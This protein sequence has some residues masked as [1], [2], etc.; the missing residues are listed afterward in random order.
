[1]AA[2]MKEVSARVELARSRFPSEADKLRQATRALYRGQCNCSYWH[3]AFGGLYLSHLRQAVYKNLIEADSIIASLEKP[4]GGAKS[5]VDLE[6]FDFNF[7]LQPEI[8]LSS[9]RIAAYVSPA[10]GGQ[11]Y[12][13]DVRETGT[14]LMATLAR[15]PEPY[16]AQLANSNDENLIVKEEGLASR[17][18]YDTR[19]RR[20]FVDKFLLE[21]AS[22]EDFLASIAEVGDFS[23]T[24]YSSRTKRTR[25]QVE[26]KLTAVEKIEGSQVRVYETL[27][28]FE[29]S[30]WRSRS[31]LLV[32]RLGTWPAI[33]IRRRM[34]SGRNRTEC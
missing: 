14:N 22:Y 25:E 5:W 9:N 10:Q 23:T 31:P 1:M 2:R 11:M 17:L 18:N 15:R 13:L 29:R 20:S 12:E 28:T 30:V 24:R 34:S 19:P 8:K 16:H 7:D 26:C 3:G 27:C 33:Q 21:D 6:T 4:V 32:K